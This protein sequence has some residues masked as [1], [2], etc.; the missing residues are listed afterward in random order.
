MQ[1]YSIKIWHYEINSCSLCWWSCQKGW[2]SKP[3]PRAAI[4]LLIFPCGFFTGTR[5]VDLSNVEFLNS[6]HFFRSWF[7]SN[8]SV[9]VQFEGSHP[10]TACSLLS[11]LLFAIYFS[12][13]PMN[14]K[15]LKLLSDSRLFFSLLTVVVVALDV[16]NVSFLCE[17]GGSLLSWSS[18]FSS[19]LCL[20][21]SCTCTH[22]LFTVS[23]APP[24]FHF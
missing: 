14:V 5:V 20:S 21:H 13:W 9:Q 1:Y 24:V 10:N 17:K 3:P 2:S 8:L 12:F 4:Y 22:T 7:V 16:V 11:E 23:L 15:S 19:V 18:I 6:S